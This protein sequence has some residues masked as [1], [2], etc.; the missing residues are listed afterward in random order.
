[1]A[2]FVLSK[3]T[4][5]S[6]ESVLE[7]IQ[8]VAREVGEERLTRERFD[9]IARVSSTTVARKFGSWFEAMDRAGISQTQALRPLKIEKETVL[10]AIREY[11]RNNPGIPPTRDA[12]ERMLGLWKGAIHQHVGTMKDLLLEAGV[13]PSP[14]GRRY[15]DAES[16]EN[17]VALWTHYGRQPNFAE[18]KRSPSTVGPKAYIRRWG[19]WRAA[20][21][22][23]INYIEDQDTETLADDQRQLESRSAVQCSQPATISRSI[24]LSTRYHVLV[25][26]RF[27][28]QIC[29]RSP[30]AQA[31]VVLHV[32]HIHPWSKGGDNS[33]SNLRVLCFDCNLGKG[34]KLEA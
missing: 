14:S 33:A 4:D 22:A 24:S 12:I 27:T 21:A 6:D 30:A 9:Q 29:G 3:L 19:G 18:L 28:C 15:T 13:E 23:F 32:D 8:R 10:S 20:L 17:I 2:K 5:Y 31:G 7:E 25:R 26:D 11:A 16:F 1:M 34:D